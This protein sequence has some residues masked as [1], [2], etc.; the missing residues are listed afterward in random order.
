MRRNT[1]LAGRGLRPD[2]TLAAASNLASKPESAARRMSDAGWDRPLA[3]GFDAEDPSREELEEQ[4]ESFAA[5]GAP[6]DGETRGP[7]DALGLYLR[8]M[9]SIPLL[10]R[11]QELALAQR[12]EHERTRYRHSALASW[13]TLTTVIETFE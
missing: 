1:K 10:T 2:P 9:G 7:D 12:L 11:D 5:A 4:E 3:V 13:H 8:Q 6:E